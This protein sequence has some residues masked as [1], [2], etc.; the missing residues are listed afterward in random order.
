MSITP[1]RVPV[2]SAPSS[3][4]GDSTVRTYAL[5]RN[6]GPGAV[7]FSSD[8][9]QGLGGYRVAAGDE[10]RHADPGQLWVVTIPGSSATLTVLEAT[11][12]HVGKPHVLST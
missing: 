6:L 3:V 1:T 11:I 10:Y 7:Y 8:P 12:S 4:L 9:G 5:C 2:T